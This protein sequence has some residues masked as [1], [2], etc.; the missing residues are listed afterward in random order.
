[1]DTTAPRQETDRIGSGR[2]Q[3]SNRRSLTVASWNVRTLVENAGED[4]RTSR[5][6]AQPISWDVECCVD[7]KLDL[8]VKELPRDIG[9]L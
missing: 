9:F 1:M 8:L 7:R 4:R 2:A 3:A 5:S 6:R